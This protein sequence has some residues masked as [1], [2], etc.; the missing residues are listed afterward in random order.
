MKTIR[1]L[2]FIAL[3][4]VFASCTKIY[5]VINGMHKP[6]IENKTTIKNF[7]DKK[8]MRQDNVYVICDTTHYFALIKCEQFPGI[9]EMWY[10]NK[11]GY[12]MQLRDPEKCN[13][14]N[15]GIINSLS[16]IHNYEVD[17][18]FTFGQFLPYL[19]TLDGQDVGQNINETPDIYAVIFWSLYTGHLNL[20]VKDWEDELYN[21]L[22]SL[23]IKVLKVNLDLQESW[24]V[25]LDVKFS[26]MSKK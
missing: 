22:S 24:N 10:F 7:L 26:F 15:T 19:K 1:F 25:P 9:P 12:F 18:L 20:K 13:A 21:T 16:D 3:I 11:D 17:S 5:L 8:E 2:S 6:R 23:K 14:E 4:S